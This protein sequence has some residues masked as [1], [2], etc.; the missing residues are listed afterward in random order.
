MIT[1]VGEYIVGSYLKTLLECDFIDYNVRP[2]G[3]GL[4]GLNELD[5]VG[6][7]F[8]NKTAYLCEVTTHIRGLHYGTHSVT[9][10]RIQKKHRN[11][12]QY[13]KKYL[14]AFPNV[15]FMFWSPYVPVGELTRELNKMKGLELY[16]NGDYKACIAYLMAEAATTTHDTRNPFFR[17][18]QIIEHMRD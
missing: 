15:H 8:K 18:L 3:G 9:I 6:L 7:H 16:I 17:M 2:P 11:Q 4:K 1:N 10:A 12:K 13:A 14:K 5:V